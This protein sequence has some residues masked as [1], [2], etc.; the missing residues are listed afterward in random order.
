PTPL[1]GSAGRTASVGARVPCSSLAAPVALLDFL[2]LLLAEAEVVT[3]LVNQRFADDHPHVVIVVAVL[4]DRLLEERHAVGQ[5]VAPSRRAL[6]ERRSLVEAVERVWRIDFHLLQQIRARLVLDDDGDVL[7]L[8][9][10]ALRDER[11][12]VSDEL[13]ELFA[14]HSSSADLKVRL[15]VRPLRLC[16]RLTFRLH[17]VWACALATRRAGNSRNRRARSTDRRGVWACRRAGR[18]E[19]GR[20]TRVSR[21]ASAVPCRVA[22]RP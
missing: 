21:S 14:G 13:L 1:R 15:Y 2:D 11:D 22:P 16:V 8:A 10:E 5:G 12:R 6:G 3:D 19:S 17:A 4:F 18:G 9:A 7:H 20:R